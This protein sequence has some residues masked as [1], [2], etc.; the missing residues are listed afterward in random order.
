MLGETIVFH[1]SCSFPNEKCQ[2]II[3]EDSFDHNKQ[4]C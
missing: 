2:Q 3:L 4:I 1:R